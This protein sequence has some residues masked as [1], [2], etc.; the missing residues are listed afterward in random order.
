MSYNFKNARKG[1]TKMAA[2]KAPGGKEY[3]HTSSVLR[4]CMENSAGS[5]LLSSNFFRTN[6]LSFFLI[7]TVVKSYS[8]LL[9]ASSLAIL[10]FLYAFF[11]SD[12]LK[13]E[14][15]NFMKGHVMA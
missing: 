13:V 2:F 4:I 3:V 11:I 5:W 6:L 10:I 9:G 7:Q 15:H 8:S 14:A 1:N 12:I